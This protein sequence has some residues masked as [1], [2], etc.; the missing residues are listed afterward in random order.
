METEEGTAGC[1]VNGLIRILF[2][3]DA[4]PV[5]DEAAD[6]ALIVAAADILIAERDRRM[7]MLCNS[8]AGIRLDD[9]LETPATDAGSPPPAQRG[10]EPPRGG[11]AQ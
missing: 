4:C 2:D 9:L 7:Q 6:P 3:I 8:S 11:D 5:E 10:W 1:N